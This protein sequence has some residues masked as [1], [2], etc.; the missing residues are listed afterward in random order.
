MQFSGPFTNPRQPFFHICLQITKL[1]SFNFFEMEEVEE[2]LDD[3]N[4]TEE[5]KKNR[6]IKKTTD[7]I[8]FKLDK[9]MEN[10]VSFCL[11]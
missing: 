1:I 7:L 11:T 5:T 3:D 6:S 8:K 10:F 4:G 2:H 9:L